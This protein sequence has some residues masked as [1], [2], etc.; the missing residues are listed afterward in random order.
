MLIL[1]HTQNPLCAVNELWKCFGSLRV[2]EIT[3][4]IG[5]K[6]VWRT[7]FF[8]RTLRFPHHYPKIPFNQIFH[9][10]WLT[11]TEC[12][13]NNFCCFVGSLERRSVDMIKTD[14]SV[15]NLSS[16]FISLFDSFCSQGFV[17]STI[18]DFSFVVSILSMASQINFKHDFYPFLGSIFRWPHVGAR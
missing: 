17:P 4:G 12:I 6:N 3:N 11:D 10:L 7:K 13:G 15:F 5:L 1:K 9:D 18:E 16:Y 2:Q 14:F 8:N